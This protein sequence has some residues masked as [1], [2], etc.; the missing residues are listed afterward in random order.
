MVSMLF[1]SDYCYDCHYCYCHDYY[2]YYSYIITT[3][4]ILFLTIVIIIIIVVVVASRLSCRP[5]A[6][7]GYVFVLAVS[8]FWSETCVFLEFFSISSLL[9]LFV[10]AFLLILPALR[11]CSFRVPNSRF[12]CFLV[13]F[14]LE[15]PFRLHFHG[16]FVVFLL[17]FLYFRRASEKP[18]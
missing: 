15:G 17:L 5:D 14:M 18:F 8:T 2:Y 12:C 13:R 9:C 11:F 16:L 10:L 1:W 7:L 3:I 6:P 4:T